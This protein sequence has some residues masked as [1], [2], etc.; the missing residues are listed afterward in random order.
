M[1]STCEDVEAIYFTQSIEYYKYL[2]VNA[3]NSN[4]IVDTSKKLWMTSSYRTIGGGYDDGSAKQVTSLTIDKLSTFYFSV[5]LFICNGELFS[6]SATGGPL[7][8]KNDLINVT[9]I[10]A[11]DTAYAISNG[12]LYSCVILSFELNY[13]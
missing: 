6:S 2:L 7:P 12:K 13:Q 8:K 3:F 11:G 1:E 5:A 9:D 4:Y 10:A